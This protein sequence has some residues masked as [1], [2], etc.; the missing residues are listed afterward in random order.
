[1]SCLIFTYQARDQLNDITNTRSP[2]VHQAGITDC[3]TVGQVG[4]SQ[5]RPHTGGNYHTP[6]W[7]ELIRKEMYKK[8]P[9]KEKFPIKA[10]EAAL[11]IEVAVALQAHILIECVR[12]IKSQQSV[13]LSPHPLLQEFDCYVS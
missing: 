11:L 3:T 13:L 6:L 8:F 9:I 7:A 2:R 4:H 5:P 10:I 12:M 1:M